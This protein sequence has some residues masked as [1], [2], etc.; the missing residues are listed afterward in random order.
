MG[1]TT[2]Y[3]KRNA[4]AGSQRLKTPNESSQFSDSQGGLDVDNGGDSVSTVS[5]RNRGVLFG[6][7]VAKQEHLFAVEGIF[8]PSDVR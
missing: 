1:K 5:V 3:R 7:V 8:R 2:K 4:N 6:G